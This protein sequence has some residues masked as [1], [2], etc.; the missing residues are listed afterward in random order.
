MVQVSISSS[1][2]YEQL[3]CAKVFCSVFLYLQFGLVIF[4][5]NNI[6]AKDAFKMLVILITG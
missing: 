4:W 3:F 1:T 6:D 5:Q 2:I